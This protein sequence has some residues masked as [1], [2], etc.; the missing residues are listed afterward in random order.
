MTYCVGLKLNA[1]MVFLADS[2]TNAGVDQIGT[3]RK[4]TVFER[5]DERVMVLLTSGNLGVTQSVRQLLMEHTTEEASVWNAP[6]M[7]D[8]ATRVGDAVRQVYD[9][10]HKHLQEL[11]IEF[12]CTLIFGGQIRGERCRLFQVY[13]AGNFIE[14]QEENL[15]FQIGESK[16]GKPILDRVV[17]P[18]TSLD[19]A[20]KCTLIS[21]DSTLRSNLSVGLPLDLLCYEADSLRVT[22]FVTIDADNQYFQMIRRTWGQR[23]KQVFTELPE[24]TW[25]SSEPGARPSVPVRAPLPPAPGAIERPAPASLQAFAAA[26]KSSAPG[27]PKG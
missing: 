13:S 25:H 6:T 10:D 3:F 19:E 7:Y 22:R 14:A 27:G 23:L 1:G 16:Y 4:L 17:T 8:A 15:Y 24:P 21:M 11:G 5:P 12:N 2:R 20:A 9:R 26:P 18:E